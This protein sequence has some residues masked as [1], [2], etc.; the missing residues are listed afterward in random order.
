MNEI[1]AL[2]ASL[3]VR[4]NHTR[5]K[6][7]MKRAEQGE[8]S[9][10]RFSVAVL[11]HREVWRPRRKLVMQR[12]YTNGGKRNF[13]KVNFLILMLELEVPRHLYGAARTWERLNALSP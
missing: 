3:A 13:L 8:K 7:L 10:Y 5:L 6:R 4:G 12:L 9:A 1:E 11:L 2:Q